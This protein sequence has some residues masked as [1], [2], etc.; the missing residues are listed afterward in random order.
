MAMR[1]RVGRQDLEVTGSRMRILPG[2]P[3]PILRLNT[4]CPYYTMFP[5]RFPFTGLFQAE[6]G[7]WVLDP[8]CGRGTSNFAARLRG[9]PSVGVDS[10]PVAAAVA[11]AKLVSCT[12]G[13]IIASARHILANPAEPKDVPAGSFW[14][15]A[16]HPDTLVDICKLREK[17]ALA[18]ETDSRIALRALVLG[19][20]HGPDT[21]G[22]PTYLSNQMPRTY[23]TKP[24]PAVRYWTKRR[25]RPR[26]VDVL[27]AITRRACFSFAQI[28]PATV[29]EVILGDSRTVNFKRRRFHWIITSPPYYG[30]RSYVPDQWLRNWFMGGPSDVAYDV[31]QQIPH[32]S[33][34][35]FVQGLA[36]VWKKVASV[37]VPS[38]RLV[39]RFGAL[40]S[41]AKN[42][43]QLLMRSLEGAASGWRV[44]T[45][46]D[47]GLASA[48]RRQYDQ[49]GPCASEPVEEIDLY[50]RLEA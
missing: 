30:M 16:Y 17:L 13:Q 10:N 34:D 27:D 50:A 28:P 22:K 24:V 43:R 31:E 39:V 33:E 26:K 40:P 41:R 48:G 12:S 29:G 6:E 44:T 19:I 3:T 32:A 47:A 1:N 4:I 38:A 9:L 36:A 49:F 7:E 15:L 18:C 20:L 11:G 14:D 35:E 42:P 2:K 5:L 46:R 21:K 45:V 37:S 23:A 25:L 8:F